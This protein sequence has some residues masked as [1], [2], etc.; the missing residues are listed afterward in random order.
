MSDEGG[1]A[2]VEDYFSEFRDRL[3]RELPEELPGSTA[4]TILVGDY[5]ATDKRSIMLFIK[6]GPTMYL[7]VRYK[8]PVPAV[9]ARVFGLEG[10]VPHDGPT[11]AAVTDAEIAPRVAAAAMRPWVDEIARLTPLQNEGDEK[12]R[13][14]VRNI[15]TYW[16]MMRHYLT[17]IYRELAVRYSDVRSSTRATTQTIDG[18]EP[19]HPTPKPNSDPRARTRTRTLSAPSSRRSTSRRPLR[20]RSANARVGPRQFSGKLTSDPTRKRRKRTV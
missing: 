15:L 6:M 20:T 5:I 13:R 19:R 17:R 12:R 16:R 18:T 1:Y 7:S 2:S 14:A 11:F 10:L 8:M 9:A 4:T 3:E